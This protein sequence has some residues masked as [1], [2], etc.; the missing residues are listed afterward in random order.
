MNSIVLPLQNLLDDQR[1]SRL[2]GRDSTIARGRPGDSCFF[3]VAC[4]R[5]TVVHF[6]IERMAESSSTVTTTVLSILSLTT[7]PTILLGG[8]PSLLLTS[9]SPRRIDSIRSCSCCSRASPSWPGDLLSSATNLLVCSSCSSVRKRR[10]KMPDGLI[11]LAQ[12]LLPLSGQLG[13]SPIR[14]FPVLG[15]QFAFLHHS[16]H[17]PLRSLPC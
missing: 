1:S 8:F 16:P 5:L 7:S 2:R 3:V 4:Y 11:S 10:L 15:H 9:L 6:A 13:R 17:S 12:A 14:L